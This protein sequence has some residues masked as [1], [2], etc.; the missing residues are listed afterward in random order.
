MERR[1][2]YFISDAHLGLRQGDPAG[3]E[4]RLVGFLK[5][6]PRDAKALYLLGDMWD[7]WYEYRDVVPKTG[8]RVVSELI[9]LMDA[10]VEVFFFEG[11][12]DIWTYSFFES[13][14]MKKLSQPSFLEIGGKTF[15]VG[16]GD[17]LGGAKRS[18]RFMMKIFHS[19]ICQVLF[20]TLHPWIAYR[21]G[22]AW[23]NSS[24]RSHAPY[25]FR[26]ADE[27]LY[28]FAADV[29]RKRPVDYFIFG[30]FHCYVDMEIPA[31]MDGTAPSR[32]LVLKDWMGGNQP[33]ALFD[34][35]KLVNIE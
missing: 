12:H 20:S 31:P 35:E 25:Q 1:L 14:G 17:A 19:R 10:G 28:A 6:I 29:L 2:V 23:S 32:L 15:C 4:A 22:N 11:N 21:F 24:R 9:Q 33:H 18:Y 13:L 30:H 34:G 16:H 27:P 3:R 8:A 26:G 5:G 7:F